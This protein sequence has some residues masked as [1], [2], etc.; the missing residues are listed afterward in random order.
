LQSKEKHYDRRRIFGV[1]AA[2]TVTRFQQIDLWPFTPRAY[3]KPN[4]VQRESFESLNYVHAQLVEMRERFIAK[5]K[6]HPSVMYVG[7]QI[8]ERGF[9]AAHSFPVKCWAIEDMLVR[10]RED[11][12]PFAVVIVKPPEVRAA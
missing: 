3:M 2:A 10:M 6:I 5:F 9:P 4:Q 11:L 1:F 12:P 8:Y 7:A